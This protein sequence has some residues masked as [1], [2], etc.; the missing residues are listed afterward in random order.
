MGGSGFNDQLEKFLQ[1]YQLT[2]IDIEG[3]SNPG[4]SFSIGYA[5]QSIGGYQLRY[6]VYMLK[7]WLNTGVKDPV[8]NKFIRLHEDLILKDLQAAETFEKDLKKTA[9]NPVSFYIEENYPVAGPI[10]RTIAVAYLIPGV[11][12]NTVQVRHYFIVNP[13]GWKPNEDE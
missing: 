6:G 3:A 13:W 7:T 8:T 11:T 10:S 4:D 5:G 2:V 9:I 1:K 12:E